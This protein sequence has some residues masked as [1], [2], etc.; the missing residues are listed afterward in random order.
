MP[1][2]KLSPSEHGE[3]SALFEWA[4]YQEGRWPEIRLMYA[5]PNW[6]VE[7][8]HR[9]YLAA[10]GVKSGVPDICL[11][12]ARGWYHGLYIEMKVV[13]GKPSTEQLWY[14]EELEKQ[15]YY[16]AICYGFEEAKQTIEEYMD[17]PGKDS[18]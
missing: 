5:V 6:R 14:K 2:P 1:K 18:P 9:A 11:P 4:A 12:V 17:L 7:E 3:Q 15:G 10:E 13:G 8:K 16:V